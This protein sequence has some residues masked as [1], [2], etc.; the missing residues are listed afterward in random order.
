MND[1]TVGSVHWSFWAIG[2]VTLIYNL[3]G[4]I[5]FITQMNADTVAAMPEMYRTMIEGRPA[6]VTGA[7]AAA[8]FGGAL[9]CILLLLRKKIALYVF[10]ASLIG[11][12]VTMIHGLGTTGSNSGPV[13]LL[14]GNLVQLVVTAVFVT[15]AIML[16]RYRDET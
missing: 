16:R 12:I 14:I 3:A 15:G 7:F 1:K 5:N 8:V 4:C 13:E 6:G 11:A 2:T 9:G 10:G